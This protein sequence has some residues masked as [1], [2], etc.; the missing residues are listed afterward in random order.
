MIFS[1]RFL[2]KLA[3]RA[4]KSRSTLVEKVSLMVLVVDTIS[5]EAMAGQCIE[6]CRLM[7]GSKLSNQINSFNY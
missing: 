3:S 4:M 7:C 2:S 5:C 6:R 1:F